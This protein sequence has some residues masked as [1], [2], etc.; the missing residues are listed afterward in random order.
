MEFLQDNGFG[1]RRVPFL[2]SIYEYEEAGQLL[3]KDGN[4]AS[5]IL[6]FDKADTS[7][8]RHHAAQCL[9]EGI[10]EHVFF[11]TNYGEQSDQLSQLFNLSEATWLSADAKTEV[12]ILYNR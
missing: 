4:H 3:W 5:A 10:A 6:R 11:A 1:E 8:S 2:E 9:R 7:S 12:R